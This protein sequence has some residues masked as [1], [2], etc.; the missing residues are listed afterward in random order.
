M[1]LTETGT[2]A[3]SALPLAPFRDHLR[4]GRGFSDDAVQDSLLESQLRAA[5]AAIEARTAKALIARDFR[6]ELP[7][8][9]DPSAQA[10]PLAPI[11]AISAITLVDGGG[12]KP[13]WTRRCGG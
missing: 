7:C 4:L 12:A 10:L 11:A 6:L 2:I 13:C 9:R 3:G 5:L 1:F 8:W